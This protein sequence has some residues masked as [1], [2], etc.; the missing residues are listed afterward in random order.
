MGDKPEVVPSSVCVSQPHMCLHGAVPVLM[1]MVQS[2][3]RAW[4]LPADC[5]RV[6]VGSLEGEK[7][8]RR[9]PSAAL[10]YLCGTLCFPA[11]TTELVG[12]GEV[13]RKADGLRAGP[14]C[15]GGGGDW[16]PVPA[17]DQDSSAGEGK[18]V[19][20]TEEGARRCSFMVSP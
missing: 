17:L 20:G 16:A 6:A 19:N 2:W 5:A 14:G 11:G 15:L 4:H 1:E 10:W 3:H 9:N 8:Q 7:E 18:P 13:Q 12:L